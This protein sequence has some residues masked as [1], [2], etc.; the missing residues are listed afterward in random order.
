MAGYP[1][2]VPEEEVSSRIA[3]GI[4]PW[5]TSLEWHGGEINKSG[6]LLLILTTG[7]ADKGHLRE[8]CHVLSFTLIFTQILRKPP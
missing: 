2:W 6:A 1:G 8:L 3:G 4:G 5:G 7:S